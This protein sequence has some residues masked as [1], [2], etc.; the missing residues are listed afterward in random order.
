[1]KSPV[2]I[3]NG[4]GGLFRF[5]NRALIRSKYDPARLKI[6]PA[7]FRD[8]APDGGQTV[9]QRVGYNGCQNTAW[10]ANWNTAWNINWNTVWNTVWNMSLV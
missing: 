7:K 4:Y 6:A 8:L 10:N 1:M 9:L 2:T 3:V 5:Y